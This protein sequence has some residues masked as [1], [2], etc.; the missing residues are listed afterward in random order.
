MGKAYDPASRFFQA[1]EHRLHYI[2]EGEGEPIVMVHG[3]PT[4]SFL[5]RKFIKELSHTHRCIA[6][7]HLGFGLSDKPSG[8]SYKPADHAAN[9]AA[10]LDKL[11]LID[12]TLIVQDWGGPT[13]LSYA[14]KNPERVK[15][16]VIMNTWFWPVEDERH[17]RLF[18]GMVGGPIGR[19][20]F[21]D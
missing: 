8:W 14:L 19:F 18:S 15:R 20:L 1:G 6:P 13:G 2:D 10:L 7:D 4:W 17:Y 16:L 21:I 9:L 3:N 11:D 12:I 5:Y